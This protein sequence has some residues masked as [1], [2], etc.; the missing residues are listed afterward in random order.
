MVVGAIDVLLGVMVQVSTAPL[1]S[2]EDIYH[3]QPAKGATLCRMHKA[4][5]QCYFPH[6]EMEL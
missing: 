4:V 1:F 6:M 3:A 2:A 5:T